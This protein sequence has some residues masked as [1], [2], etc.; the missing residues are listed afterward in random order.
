MMDSSRNESSEPLIHI[1]YD[2]LHPHLRDLLS[3]STATST[4]KSPS[5]NPDPQR[6]LLFSL[7][8][9]RMHRLVHR[10]THKTTSDVTPI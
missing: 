3:F 2:P 5:S 4:F 1:S 8:H 9:H 10:S 7:L 6:R